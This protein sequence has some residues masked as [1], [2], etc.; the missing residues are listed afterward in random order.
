MKKNKSTAN[1]PVRNLFGLLMILC[2][3]AVG[4]MLWRPWAEKPH[5]N[6]VDTT[7]VAIAENDPGVAVAN[8]R[9]APSTTFVDPSFERAL[10]N[11]ASS[12]NTETQA[13]IQTSETAPSFDTEVVAADHTADEATRLLDVLANMVQ[14]NADGLRDEDIGKLQQQLMELASHDDRVIKMMCAAFFADQEGLQSEFIRQVLGTQQHPAVEGLGLAMVVDGERQKVLAGLDLLSELGI[15]NRNTFVPVLQLMENEQDDTEILTKSVQS[16]RPMPLPPAENARLLARLGQLTTHADQGLRVESLF[17]TARWAKS[18]EAIAPVVA[19]L[20]SEH[21][22]DR[23][24]AAM[25]LKE[26]TQVSDEMRE[27]LVA[28]MQ[29]TDE[30]WFLRRMAF[31]SLQRFELG[32]N[33]FSAVSQFGESIEDILKGGPVPGAA[34][35]VKAGPVDEPVPDVRVE[36]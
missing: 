26:S 15:P 12:A 8:E 23:L 22:E 10:Q 13:E 3:I 24:S 11:K 33:D 20:S 4:V 9:V 7:P 36:G 21:R 19:A 25:A 27:G 30:E 34:E 5:S 17:A 1:Q 14:D 16:I 31:D 35:D 2:L 32:E 28:L 29:N 18:P 6:H